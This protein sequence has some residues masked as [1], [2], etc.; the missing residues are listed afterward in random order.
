METAADLIGLI[1]IRLSAASVIVAVE[2]TAQRTQD[3][4]PRIILALPLLFFVLASAPA[5]AQD[6]NAQ[7]AHCMTMNGAVERL[8]CYDRV[9]RQAVGAAPQAAQSPMMQSPMPQA[10]MAPSADPGRDFGK[11]RVAPVEPQNDR[12]TAEITDFQKDARGHF[13]VVLQ[14]GQ[15]WR[16][17]AGDTGVAQLR[18]GRTH[19]AI[20]SRG[21]LGS[22]DLR[23][24][25]QNGTFKVQRLR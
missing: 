21:A 3:A 2:T 22:Y 18:S 25:S 19:Q 11:E 9:A 15:M 16:Q 7:L 23:F 10:R 13:T 20:I 12:F 6:I 14:N 4:M 24:D 17:A 8:S 5:R 1:A